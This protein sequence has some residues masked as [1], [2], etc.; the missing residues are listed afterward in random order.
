MALNIL[1]DRSNCFAA[2]ASAEFLVIFAASFKNLEYMVRKQPP[3]VPPISMKIYRL[4]RFMRSSPSL[5]SMGHFNSWLA[6]WRIPST[7]KFL[8][9]GSRW[10][11]IVCSMEETI[12]TA[13]G[14]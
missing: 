4:K 3:P 13:L 6:V 9:G 7:P 5:K 12:S 1:P 2:A 14:L 11:S 8:I 10:A